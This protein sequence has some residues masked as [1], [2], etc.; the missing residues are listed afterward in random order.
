ML[1]SVP[2]PADE[3]RRQSLAWLW[4]RAGGADEASALLG[5]ETLQGGA[6]VLA[7]LAE[8]R[9]LPGLLWSLCTD[10]RP[11]VHALGSRFCHEVTAAATQAFVHAPQAQ[12]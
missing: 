6:A 11:E 9:A 3:G 1:R 10:P 8:G 2:R 5:T 7:A 12:R 4:L